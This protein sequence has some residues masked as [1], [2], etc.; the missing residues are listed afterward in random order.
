[1]LA[2]N[3]KVQREFWTKRVGTRRWE[4]SR[5]M[6]KRKAEF[7]ID[8][9]PN[10]E[11][12][13]VA[14]SVAT[15]TSGLEP[16]ATGRQPTGV[17]APS[18]PTLGPVGSLP[19]PVERGRLLIP[20]IFGRCWLQPVIKSGEYWWVGGHGQGKKDR[21]RVSGPWP[22]CKKE[23]S[24]VLSRGRQEEKERSRVLD[25]VAVRVRRNEDWVSYPLCSR[26][27]RTVAVTGGIFRM[28]WET[29]WP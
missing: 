4:V 24:R 26:F 23:R 12:I 14:D 18:Q 21:S 20:I 10:C 13:V 7:S 3:V 27:G 2:K 11:G 6:V 25:P 8:I 28:N 5:R 29:S 15:Y 17:E 9:V 22:S 16:R 19:I 1:M